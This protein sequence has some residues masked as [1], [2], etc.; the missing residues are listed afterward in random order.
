MTDHDDDCL[1]NL[2]ILNSEL[3]RLGV[4]ALISDRAAALYPPGD[5]PSLLRA[6]R[7]Y[8]SKVITDLA[9]M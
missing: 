9:G 3:Q 1:H 5:L 4:P 6:T 7:A 2:H 8:L